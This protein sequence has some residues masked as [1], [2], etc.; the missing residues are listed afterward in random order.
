[1]PEIKFD[2][3]NMCDSQSAYEV[4]NLSA[5]EALSVH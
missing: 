3:L 5:F 2:S 1:M 4:F